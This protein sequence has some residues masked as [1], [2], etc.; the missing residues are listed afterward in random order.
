MGMI[1][2]AY[3]ELKGLGLTAEHLDS[4][5]EQERKKVEDNMRG[6]ENVQSI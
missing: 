6:D 4:Y 2:E 5:L 1:L 3:A